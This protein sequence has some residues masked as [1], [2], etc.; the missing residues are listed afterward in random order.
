VQKAFLYLINWLPAAPRQRAA[1]LQ[2]LAL[3]VTE[4]R[5]YSRGEEP[6]A[7]EKSLQR[8]GVW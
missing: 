7:E 4:T 5:G 6:A 1:F 2:Q 8:G 3:T